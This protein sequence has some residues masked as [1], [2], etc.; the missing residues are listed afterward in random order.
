MEVGDRFTSNSGSEFIVIEYKN[1]NKVKIRFQ[2]GYETVKSKDSIL[3]GKVKDKLLASVYNV[4]FIGVGKFNYLSNFIVRWHGMLTRCYGS[5][6]GK[7][8]A[9]VCAEWHNFQNFA[10]WCSE[11]EENNLYREAWELDKDIFSI[12]NNKIYSPS[13]CCFVPDEINFAFKEKNNKI[14]GC[15][16][17]SKR[18]FW[19]AKFN[20]RYIGQFETKEK[21]TEAH[22]LKRKEY[23][24]SLANKYRN[25]INCN[26]YNKIIE[27]AN[28]LIEKETK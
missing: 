11:Q 16:F 10:G 7:N 5:S 23:I 17:S 14:E 27:R 4:G 22:A 18:N 6:R 1:A 9:E 13:T 26:I 15:Y 28:N 19:V 12:E 20:R 8:P 25:E 24:I 21:A 3:K 2:S